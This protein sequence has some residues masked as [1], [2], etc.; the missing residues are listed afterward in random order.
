MKNK[1]QQILKKRK[2]DTIKNKHS[3]INNRKLKKLKKIIT[4]S[5][6]FINHQPVKTCFCILYAPK[7]YNMNMT[8]IDPDYD[9]NI[10]KNDPP[11]RDPN[12][13]YANGN[14]HN[15]AGLLIYNYIKKK[16][17]FDNWFN[18]PL[19]SSNDNYLNK[20]TAIANALNGLTFADIK[21]AIEE[22]KE[23]KENE[24][25]WFC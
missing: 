1:I 21:E 7:Y 20:G 12:C 10:I 4:I 9:K 5:I 15:H 23:E 17:D 25:V 19:R 6:T 22:G 16:Y 24:S 2:E 13:T 18:N 11:E 14:K 3:N 8:F